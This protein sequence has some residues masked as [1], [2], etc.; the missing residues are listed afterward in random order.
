MTERRLLSSSFVS[1]AICAGGSSAS[2]CA[3]SS[4]DC[5]AI[6]VLRGQRRL[7]LRE[8]GLRAHGVELRVDL[9]QALVVR[10]DAA[11]GFE[12]GE[13]VVEAALIERRAGARDQQSAEAL[14]AF[15]G[16][17]IAGIERQH[18]AEVVRE[19]CSWRARCSGARPSRGA[20][21]S[22][23]SSSEAA[24]AAVRGRRGAGG[25]RRRRQQIAAA[26]VPSDEPLFM[27]N[28]APPATA[29]TAAAM[30]TII[31]GDFRISLHRPSCRSRN[32]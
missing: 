30:P 1:C 2:F 6:E 27:K 20:R 8:R 5:G 15:G 9:D 11:R 29:S 12:F 28:Q 19:R 17:G 13:R 22:S 21:F 24:G 18:L 14:Q 26:G 25:R 7:D 23:T 3:A 32:W 4:S 10:V 16:F 31:T